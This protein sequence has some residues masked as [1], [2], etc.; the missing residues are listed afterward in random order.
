MR[1]LRASIA[2]GPVGRAGRDSGPVI[3]RN[4]APSGRNSLPAMPSRTRRAT[5]VT[6]LNATPDRQIVFT[7]INTRT[8]DI[9]CSFAGPRKL[10]PRLV[11]PTREGKRPETRGNTLAPL[12][13][14]LP[15][16][17]N[18]MVPSGT[19]RY[20]KNSTCLAFVTS[21]SPPS[22]RPPWPDKQ[23]MAPRS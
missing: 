18:F 20:T 12:A 7:Q 8:R 2:P 19:T 17:E 22:F 14:S 1:G 23:P 21:L 11:G 4:P 13:R 15:W 10:G 16:L 5:V 9:R 6:I 3:L